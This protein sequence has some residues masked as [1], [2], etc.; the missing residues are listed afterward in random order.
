MTIHTLQELQA[1]MD[2]FS[3]ACKDFGLTI[4]LKKTKV[5]GQDTMELPLFDDYELDVVEHFTYLGSTITDNLSLDT[6]IHKRSEKAA[7]TFARLTSRVWANPKL[8]VKTEMVVYNARVVSTLM[9]GSETW[10][11]YTRQEKTQFLPPEKHP[12]HI[13]A[14]QS[15]QHRGHVPSQPSK[16]VHLAQTAQAAL[17]GVCLQHGGWPHPKRHSLRKV[18]FKKENQSRP[19]LNYKEL[20]KRDNKELNINTESWENLAADRMMWRSTL[21]Q[22][23]KSGEE[24][25]LNAEVG[26]KIR[27]KE[28]NN[29]SRA[30][31][32]HKYDFLR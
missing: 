24:K 28:R 32:T 21:N 3:Q 5:L 25:L 22:H 15:V 30:E 23:L 11:T 12:G 1:L 14:K 2:R 31:T 27:R 8:T 19:H 4:S 6:E 20:C 17:A 29:S 7:T 26:K 10:I 9:Y 18:G 13:R 16:H